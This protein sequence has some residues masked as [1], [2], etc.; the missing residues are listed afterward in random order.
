[1]KT[2]TKYPRI[3][4]CD[5]NEI[6]YMELSED[7][8]ERVEKIL[9]AYNEDKIALEAEDYD[10]GAVLV[11]NDEDYEETGIEMLVL[12]WYEGHEETD[13]LIDCLKED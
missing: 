3:E 9:E 5:E 7:A 12:N 11:I 8:L 6:L 4:E 10:C 1:M 2:M 13:Y